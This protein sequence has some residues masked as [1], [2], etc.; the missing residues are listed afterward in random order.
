MGT[1]ECWLWRYRNIE[2]GRICRTMFPCSAE[3]ARRLYPDAERIAGTMILRE[4]AD[5]TAKRESA[6][7]RATSDRKPSDAY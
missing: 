7:R 4:V 3:E 6:S 2:T 1:V 5:E